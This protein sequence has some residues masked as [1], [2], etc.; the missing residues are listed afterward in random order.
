MPHDSGCHISTEKLDNQRDRIGPPDRDQPKI[1]QAIFMGAV[2]DRRLRRSG[3]LGLFAVLLSYRNGQT[4]EC[5]PAYAT[6]AKLL[7]CSVSGISRQ[8]AELRKYGIVKRTRR[9]TR[10]GRWTSNLYYLGHDHFGKAMLR[11]AVE[12]RIGT[13]VIAVLSVMVAQLQWIHGIVVVSAHDIALQI[14]R[15]ASRV[16]A[17]L[18]SLIKNGHVIRLGE[19]TYTF[20]ALETRAREHLLRRGSNQSCRDGSD[21]DMEDLTRVEVAKLRDGSV[22]ESDVGCVAKV[23]SGEVAEV[24]AEPAQHKPMQK[25]DAQCDHADVDVR[26]AERIYADPVAPSRADISCETVENWRSIIGRRCSHLTELLKAAHNFAEINDAEILDELARATAS[27]LG[28]RI[29][30]PEGLQDCRDLICLIGAASGENEVTSVKFLM[31]AIRRKLRAG[32]YLNS[33]SLIAHELATAIMHD[34]FRLL[35]AEAESPGWITPEM[36]SQVV[37]DLRARDRNR[38]LA[39][40]LL[41]RR[42][43][44]PYLLLIREHGDRAREVVNAALTSSL[45]DGAKS[46]AEIK[47][48]AYF[49][50]AIESRLTR[51]PQVD[52]R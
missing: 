21:D 36:I 47:T 9:V 51:T 7:N 23:A 4:G 6:I 43:I 26:F 5:F 12:G 28:M 17:A 1:V 10:R 30:S 49:Q 15:E 31:A 13:V 16:R 2:T 25:E 45:I 11:A 22:A 48:W 39:A 42:G 32:C 33:W 3:P 24:S 14:R 20:P 44:E 41:S 52:G 27:R 37:N 38:I 19:A 8:L 18:A 46:V 40:K 35:R 34:N 29:A 50:A